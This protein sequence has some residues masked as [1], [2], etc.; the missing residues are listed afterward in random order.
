M[1]I[2]DGKGKVIMKE[3]EQRIEADGGKEKKEEIVKKN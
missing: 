1:D 3:R 2:D